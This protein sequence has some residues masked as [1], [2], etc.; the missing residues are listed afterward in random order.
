MNCCLDNNARKY[1]QRFDKILYDMSCKMLSRCPTNSI[2]LDFIKCMIPHHQAAIYMCENLL[3][4]TC[5]P[6]LKD[7]AHNIIRTQTNGIKQMREIASTTTCLNNT[8]CDVNRYFTQYR[9]ITKN[10]VCKM[11]SAPRCNNINL[12]FTNEMIPHHEGAVEM[13]KNLLKYPIDCRLEEIAQ[14]I[15][16]EQSEGICELKRIRNDLCNNH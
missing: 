13:C 12:N 4:Y 14:N 16:T 6:P 15:I 11:R 8:C 1:I 9:N 5:Y 10:M 2:T 7:I 3:Q